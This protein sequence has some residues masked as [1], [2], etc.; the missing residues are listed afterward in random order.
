MGLTGY[1]IISIEHGIDERI[2]WVYVGSQREQIAHTT[3]IYYTSS[4]RAYFRPN[5][6]RRIYLDECMRAQ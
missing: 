3:K 5:A 2:T 6:Y 1:E 4:G